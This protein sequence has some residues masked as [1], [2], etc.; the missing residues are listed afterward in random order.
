MRLYTIQP[1]FVYDTLCETGVFL[2][3]P[4]RDPSNWI[5]DDA[6]VIKLAYD[7]LR[8]AMVERGLPKPG[9]DTYPIWAWYQ[10]KGEQKRKPDLRCSDLKNYARDGCHVL[11]TL[12][13]PTE[14][15]LL[16]DF[17]AWHYPLNYF[18]LAAQ[19]VSDRFER[20]C[21]AAG[22]PLY[23]DVP[24]KNKE[25]H[26]EV[27]QSWH[28]IFDLA[29]CRRLFKRSRAEQSVQATFWSLRVTHV[30]AVVEFGGGQ[31]C[32][33]LPLPRCIAGS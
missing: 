13:V 31:R 2:S 14:D 3:E 22:H 6:P 10:Y 4:W 7:W 21:K 16:H 28:R 15:V 8:D 27:Q 12:D 17:E 5:C 32:R 25:L 24:L 11:L 23:M 20:H 29:T 30:S 33:I 18:Y 19:H 9:T 26:D 1:R